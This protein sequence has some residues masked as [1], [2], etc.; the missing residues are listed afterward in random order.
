MSREPA[1]RTA[2]ALLTAD[3]WGLGS[4][5]LLRLPYY[6]HRFRAGGSDPRAELRLIAE[7]PATSAFDGGNGLGHWQLWAA[8]ELSARKARTTGI[9]AVSVANSGHCGSLGLYVLPMV[10]E[11]LIGLAFSNGPAVMPPWGGHAP[12]LAT[13]PIAAGIPTRPRPAI[14]DLAT[15]AVA[16]GT[17]AQR[18]ARQEP[19]EPGW[20]FDATGQSTIDP[21]A[22]LTGMLAPMGGPKGYALAFLVESLTGGLVGPRLAGDVADPLSEAAAGDP[23]GIGH[24]V[25]ALDPSFLDADGASAERLATLAARICDAGGRPPGWG[26][27][28]DTTLDDEEP[29]ALPAA[30][31]AAL[32]GAAASLGVDLP[33]RWPPGDA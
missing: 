1:A 29:L 5:G 21:E 7:S 32:A 26:R 23:Q 12:V 16:R 30:T 25:L 15:S 24:L 3:L 18:R 27:R 33:E 2:W 6:L 17:I 9:A 14:V 28:T 11:G 10:A 13:S 4:H 8:A 22:A 19:L 31:R 20:A